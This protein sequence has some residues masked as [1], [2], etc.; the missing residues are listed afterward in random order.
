L[1]LNQA[2]ELEPLNA[3]A[4]MYRGLAKHDMCDFAGAILDFSKV[5]DEL[6]PNEGEALINRGY[7]RNCSGD[8]AGAIFDYDKA[9]DLGE[10]NAYAYFVRGKGR[11]L[12]ND[13]AGALLDFNRAIKWDPKSRKPVYYLW[14]AHVTAGE[15]ENAASVIHS[16]V[17]NFKE[18]ADLEAWERS[19]EGYIVGTLPEEQFLEAAEAE[20]PTP[21]ETRL[22]QSLYF[23]GVKALANGDRAKAVGEF[24]RVMQPI[25][26][27]FIEYKMVELELRKLGGK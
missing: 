5:I 19:I 11:L 23:V 27:K 3:W 17:N 21:R 10:S 26:M 2:I 25:N 7:A 4:H 22:C 1:E 6:D 18:N 12:V 24:R 16:I 8:H 9:V 15:K 14:A 20:G 13:Y